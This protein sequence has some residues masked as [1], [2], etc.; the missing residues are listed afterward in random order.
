VSGGGNS[1]TQSGDSD[2]A[3]KLPVGATSRRPVASA[4]NVGLIRYNTTLAKF[5]GVSEG[6][7]DGSPNGTYSW[8]QFSVS[9]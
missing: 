8:V 6:I 7:T 1:F 2:T 4:A 5:E 9:P 3:I